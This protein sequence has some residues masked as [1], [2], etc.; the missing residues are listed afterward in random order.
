MRHARALGCPRLGVAERHAVSSPTAPRGLRRDSSA[1][2]PRAA[3]RHGALPYVSVTLLITA[4]A[5][6]VPGMPAGAI[7]RTWAQ[8][9]PDGAQPPAEV[10]PADRLVAQLAAGERFDREGVVLGGALDLRPVG[11]VRS[12]VRCH[13]CTFLGSFEATDV[14]FER[15]VDLMGSTFAAPLRMR[16]TTFREPALFDGATFA[17]DVTLAS[18]RFLDGASFSAATFEHQ[19]S[20]EGARVAR[21]GDFSQCKFFESVAFTRSQF[22]GKADFTQAT[23]SG[24]GRFDSSDLDAGGSFRAAEF[25]GRALFERLTL[26]KTLDFRGATF[27]GDAILNYVEG[28]GTLSLEGIKV[29][30]DEHSVPHDRGQPCHGDPKEKGDHGAHLFTDQIAVEHLRMEVDS[31]GFVR[32]SD[33][34][35]R[36]LEII[37]RSAEAR[38]DLGVANDARFRRLSIEGAEKKGLARRADRVLYRAVAGYFVKPLHPLSAL[39]LLLVAASF[40]RAVPQVV[41]DVAGRRRDTS[42]RGSSRSHGAIAGRVH[43][44]VLTGERAGAAWLRALAA[45]FSAVMRRK[46]DVTMTCAQDVRSYLRAGAAWLELVT[47]KVLVAVFLVALGNSNATVR[48]VFDAVV[49]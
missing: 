49:S 29:I 35:K 2:G 6:F 34:Q 37:E 21:T 28:P 20:F 8:P 23:F 11:I 22:D 17:A 19:A 40:V 25:T 43:D 5:A 26:G 15:L 32:G 16:G 44:V 30:H 24:D 3:F 12:P 18:T 46:P 41:P 14:V 47:Y 42:G 48:Q 27:A 7:G 4:M 38:E 36:L 33:A 39:L 31:C 10:M 9:P 13:R 1:N 45:S